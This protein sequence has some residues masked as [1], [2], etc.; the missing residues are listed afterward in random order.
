[1]EGGTGRSPEVG[2]GESIPEAIVAT[3][4]F[5]FIKMGSDGSVFNVSFI[6]TG[7]LFGNFH[8]YYYY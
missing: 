5:F 2:G 8:Y 6:V 7:R 4:F 3:N 1:M